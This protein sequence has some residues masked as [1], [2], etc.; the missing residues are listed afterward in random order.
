M[1]N[2][3][4]SAR[5][6]AS[7]PESEPK[8]S[9]NP[10]WEDFLCRSTPCISTCGSLLPSRCQEVGKLE[11]EGHHLRQLQLFATEG[12]T[13]CDGLWYVLHLVFIVE[14]LFAL[15]LEPPEEFQCSSKGEEHSMKIRWQ[16]KTQID[17]VCISP[18]KNTAL[19]P[20]NKNPKVSCRMGFL[21]LFHDSQQLC[22]P[23][24]QAAPH[25]AS[26]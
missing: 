7:Q 17:R 15:S 22:S 11:Q 19:N 24:D 3:H 23:L 8:P 25:T 5:S 20:F 6:S 16:C 26:H 1:A 14:C 2:P 4:S 18:W 12:S 21:A 10:R 9:A 13:F